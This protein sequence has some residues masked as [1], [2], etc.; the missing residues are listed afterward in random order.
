PR[1]CYSIVS[2]ASFLYAYIADNSIVYSPETPTND[3]EES[4]L[5]AGNRIVLLPA[6]V[7]SMV[8]RVRVAKVNSNA[9][10]VRIPALFARI[11]RIGKSSYVNVVCYDSKIVVKML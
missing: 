7:K 3:K 11:L 4:I 9:L 8:Y 6:N 10:A 2:S 5:V 1:S